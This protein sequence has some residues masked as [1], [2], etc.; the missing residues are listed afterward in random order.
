MTLDATNTSFRLSSRLSACLSARARL[1]V[2]NGERLRYT[3]VSLRKDGTLPARAEV[4][5]FSSADT[6]EEARSLLLRIEGLNPTG[7]FAIVDRVE[8]VAV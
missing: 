2:L 5:G 1:P 3:V 4:N 6:V 8:R 7:R